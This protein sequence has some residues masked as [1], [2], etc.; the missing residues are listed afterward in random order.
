M[1][2]LRS[3]KGQALEPKKIEALIH[4]VNEDLG[5]RVHHAV[6]RTKCQLSIAEVARF[7]SRMDRSR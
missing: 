3:V 1:N 7:N 5:Y 6:Q 4:L 2:L